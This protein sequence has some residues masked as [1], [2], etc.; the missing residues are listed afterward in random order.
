MREYDDA[1]K[2]SAAAHL[3]SKCLD[4]GAEKATSDGRGHAFAIRNLAR[5]KAQL[6]GASICQRVTLVY[7]AY[8]AS[9]PEIR[10][11]HRE[12]D[13]NES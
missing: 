11:F 13:A 8:D 10:L 12:A 7:R 4:R 2:L 9:F 3:S 5:F 1:R 6:R